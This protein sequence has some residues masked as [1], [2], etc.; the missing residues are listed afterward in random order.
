MSFL[1]S[2][3]GARLL[4]DTKCMNTHNLRAYGIDFCSGRFETCTKKFYKSN[5]IA[6]RQKLFR[7]KFESE[8]NKNT[9]EEN[10]DVRSVHYSK[11]LM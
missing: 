11:A 3:G 2:L 5:L 4:F 7:L 6:Y 8:V 10:L 9:V 1:V